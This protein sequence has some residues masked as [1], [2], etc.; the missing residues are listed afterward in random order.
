MPRSMLN[1]GKIILEKVS[2]DKKLFWKEYDKACRDLKKEEC[3]Q[4]INWITSKFKDSSLV[5][6]DLKRSDN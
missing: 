5:K 1:Y 6:I 2:F 3:D 4:L